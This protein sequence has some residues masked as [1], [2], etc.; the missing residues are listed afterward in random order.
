MVERIVDAA[1]EVDRR[2]GEH[3]KLYEGEDALA[4]THPLPQ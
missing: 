4:L 2:L 3:V 1:A